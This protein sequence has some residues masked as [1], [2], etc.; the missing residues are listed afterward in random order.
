MKGRGGEGSEKGKER[1]KKRKGMKKREERGK[2]KRKN[3]IRKAMVRKLSPR[4]L[5][6]GGTA[7]CQEACRSTGCNNS[8][9]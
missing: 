5:G 9:T 7:N 2:K 4:P 1:K 3:R 6:A 8:S